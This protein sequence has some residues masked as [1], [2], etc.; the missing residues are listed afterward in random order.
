MKAPARKDRLEILA[1]KLRAA[2]S[3]ETS[4]IVDIGDL[5]RES[6]KL[7]EH[8]EWQAWLAKNF[9][10]TYRTALNYCNAAEYAARHKSETVSHLAPT[11]LYALAAGHYSKKQET[12]ILVAARENRVDA[13]RADAICRKLV[14]PPS[15][16]PPE[17]PPASATSGD[18]V[19]SD[20]DINRILDGPPPAVPPPAPIAPPDNFALRSF[21]Q[22]VSMLKQLATKPA[23]QFTGT[24]HGASD[25]QDVESFIRSIA[26]RV[27]GRAPAA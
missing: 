21:N 7:L 15:P 13:G 24:V 6:R 12:A 26:G 18:S 20:D 3:R 16:S 17:P 5:L 2:L 27:K 23:A 11:L 8:G 4:N 25:L 10:L 14:P 1:C 19:A 22:A 9:D